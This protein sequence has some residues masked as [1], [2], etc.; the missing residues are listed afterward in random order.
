MRGCPACIIVGV[1]ENDEMKSPK[2]CYSA[3]CLLMLLPMQSSFAAAG[4]GRVNMQGAVIE[5]ACAIDTESRDQT[6]DMSIAPLSQIIRD[7]KGL[8][9]HSVFVWLIVYWSA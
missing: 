2:R 3:F 9:A 7:G 4:W 6:I 5:T 8:R 1:Q